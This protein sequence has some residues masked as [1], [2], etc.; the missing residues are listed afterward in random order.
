VAVLEQYLGTSPGPGSIEVVAQHA[1]SARKIDLSGT[2]DLLGL[3]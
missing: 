3:G 2:S 1:S